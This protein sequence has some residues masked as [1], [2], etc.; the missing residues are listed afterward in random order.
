MVFSRVAGQPVLVLNQAN[1]PS[2][3]GQI[4]TPILNAESGAL[5]GRVIGFHAWAYTAFETARSGV[6]YSAD[7]GI[8]GGFLSTSRIQ[9]RANSSNRVYA[10]V[11]QTPAE[12][13]P[14]SLLD[15][16]PHP[17][18]SKVIHSYYNGMNFKQAVF[19]G[20]S[21]AWT[22]GG[23]PNPAMASTDLE[24][25]TDGRYVTVSGD[26]LRLYAL[27]GTE[28]FQWVGPAFGTSPFGGQ[29][30]SLRI[31]SDGLRLL[32]NGM[33]VGLPPP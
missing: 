22:D 15:F 19:N 30:G 10:S 17:N 27:D 24:F 1:E 26:T 14:S 28:Q 5:V 18:G 32:G 20:T 31:S 12:T 2:G 13:P 21:L 7:M 6:I 3:G 33:F 16:A 8:T 25:L 23:P 9:L 11:T 29:A 4:I